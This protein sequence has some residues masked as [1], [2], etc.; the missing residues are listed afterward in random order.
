MIQFLMLNYNMKEDDSFKTHS[1][2]LFEGQ[3]LRLPMPSLDETVELMYLS[4]A[5]RLVVFHLNLNIK[6]TMSIRE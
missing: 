4:F 5:V 2:R 3:R 6:L 1:S